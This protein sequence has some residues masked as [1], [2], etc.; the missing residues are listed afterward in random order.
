MLTL[1]DEPK[2]LGLTLYA[3]HMLMQGCCSGPPTPSRTPAIVSPPNKTAI[4]CRRV[5]FTTLE[6]FDGR[7]RRG[8]LPAE[9]KQIAGRAGRFGKRFSHGIVTAL[10]KVSCQALSV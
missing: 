2:P 1:I 7:S 4:T 3:M 10:H 5:V 6:K 8:L 9:V